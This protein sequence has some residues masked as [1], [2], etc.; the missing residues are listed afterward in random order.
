MSKSTGSA[1]K[2]TLHH[3]TRRSRFS[4]RLTINYIETS[5]ACT[6]GQERRVRELLSEVR[7]AG[8]NQVLVEGDGD[9]ADICQLT[10]LEQGIQ[11]SQ[12][13]TARDGNQFTRTGSTRFESLSVDGWREW[14]CQAMNS[15]KIVVCA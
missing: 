8:Y 5:T 1:Q 10:C 2:T 4:A 6:A 11:C 9:I 15:G 12:L 7:L 3:H 13:R 14:K